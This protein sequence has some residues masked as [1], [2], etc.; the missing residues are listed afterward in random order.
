[1]AVN[2]LRYNLNPF[3]CIDCGKQLKF[4]FPVYKYTTSTGNPVLLQQYDFA[5]TPKDKGV[6]GRCLAVRIANA[7]AEAKL[8]KGDHDAYSIVDDGSIKYMDTCVCCHEYTETMQV[9]RQRLCDIRFGSSWWNGQSV[10][11]YCLASTARFGEQ[12]SGVKTFV[13]GKMYNVNERGA[14]IGIAHWYTP[15]FVKQKRMG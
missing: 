11:E 15:L 1:M 3:L 6:C 9:C 2:T 12:T 4:R 13:G 8:L 10:C 7:F 5:N 14:L